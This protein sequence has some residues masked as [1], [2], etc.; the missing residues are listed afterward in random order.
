[1]SLFLPKIVVTS[2]EPSGAG[3]DVCLHLLKAKLPARISIIGDSVVFGQRAKQLGLE[4]TLKHLD[5]ISVPTALPVIAGRLESKNVPMVL[6]QLDIAIQG[7][8]R[9]QF[10]AMVTAPLHKGVINEA[11]Y[12]FSGHT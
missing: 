4:D 1:M 7:C 2:G 10:H 9:K 3:P 5:L 6:E 8:V 12:A 11:G